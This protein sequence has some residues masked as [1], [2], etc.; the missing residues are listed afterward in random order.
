MDET[1]R[2][3]MAKTTARITLG[4]LEVL[5]IEAKRSGV[6]VQALAG[7]LLTHGYNKLR[8]EQRAAQAAERVPTEEALTEGE[9]NDVSVKD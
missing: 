2:P 7:M 8:E 9:E 1:K 3:K 4:L 5:K 6:G